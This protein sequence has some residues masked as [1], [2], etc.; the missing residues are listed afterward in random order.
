MSKVFKKIY[1]LL[2]STKTMA[3][4][5][6]IFALAMAIATFIENDFGT[7]TARTLI[8]NSWWFEAIMILLAVNLIGN[9]IRFKMYQKKKWPV[10][11][12]HIAFLLI[13]VGAGITRY[14]S[15]EGM[16]PIREGET[17]DTFLSDKVFLKVHID[18]GIDQINPPI[19]KVLKLSAI[20]VPFLTDNHYKTEIDFKG[21]PVKIEVLNFVPHAKDTLILDPKGD[22]HLQFVVST[23]QGRQNIY[24]PDGKQISVGDKHL[25]FNNTYPDAINVFIKNDSLFLL[26]PYK[27]T[28]MRMQ[29]QKRFNVPKDS[30]VPFHLASLY[31]LNG[32]NFV[33]PQGPVRGHLQNISGDKNANLSD[34][35]QV[36]VTSGNQEKIVGLSGGQGQPEN[37]KIFQLNGLNFRMSYGSVFRHLPFQIKLRD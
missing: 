31:Q 28:Y 2:I 35:L 1:H 19:E 30:I 9:I 37:P 15:F 13:L 7:P 24:L 29:D 22:W 11:L 4:L 12:F 16:M 23:P 32:L 20:D 10:F 34:L 27:G 25:A 6:V 5:F 14:I 33:V 36:K 3:V 8:Y 18:D 26:S 21:K 17:T